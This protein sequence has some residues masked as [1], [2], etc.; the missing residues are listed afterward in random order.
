MYKAIWFMFMFSVVSNASN[1]T[2]KWTNQKYSKLVMEKTECVLSNNGSTNIIF[3]AILTVNLD[4]S[5]GITENE[6][7]YIDSVAIEKARSLGISSIV[8]TSWLEYTKQYGHTTGIIGEV[9]YKCYVPNDLLE[10]QDQLRYEQQRQ[11]DQF[12]YEQQRQHALFIQESIERARIYGASNSTQAVNPYDTKIA[13]IV[14]FSLACAAGSCLIGVGLDTQYS[15]AGISGVVLTGVSIPFLIN[16][17]RKTAQ[18]YRWER[19]H[20]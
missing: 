13:K 4:I 12:R 17:I 10:K 3:A 1:T 14:W 2:L 5:E 9:K 6:I 8:R 19:E 16:G 20:K 18:Y 11:Q 7:E 15:D